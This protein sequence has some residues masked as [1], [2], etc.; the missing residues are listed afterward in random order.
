MKNKIAN[1]KSGKCNSFIINIDDIKI[2]IDIK[3]ISIAWILIHRNDIYRYWF[4]FLFLFIK[5]E[6]L[7]LL[8]G[9]WLWRNQWAIF[10]FLFLDVIHIKIEIK[11]TLFLIASGICSLW[12]INHCLTNK[13]L[14]QLLILLMITYIMNLFK[15]RNY[16]TSRTSPYVSQIHITSTCHVITE[17]L[18]NHWSTHWP[19]IDKS[20]LH[21]F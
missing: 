11:S 15:T 14:I 16:H 4:F 12:L 21:I 19:F 8:S 18:T 7:F 13:L 9:F 5:I 6:R 3:I 17:T 10:T 1:S 2:N 20:F